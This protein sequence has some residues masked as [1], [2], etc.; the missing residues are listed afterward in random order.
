M[1]LFPI[2]EV[3]S[4][5]KL[6]GR[7]AK[8]EGRNVNG[9]DREQLKLVLDLL[10]NDPEIAGT[11]EEF[12][13]AKSR[14]EVI[15]ANSKFNLRLW[16]FLGI[17]DVYDGEAHRKEM[18]QSV[19]ENVA[20][21][22]KL[23]CQVSFN[24]LERLP[25]IFFPFSYYGELSLAKPLHVEETAYIL[26]EARKPVK[27]PIT[28]AYTLATWSDLGKDPSDLVK[29]GLSNSEARRITIEKL[30]MEFADKIINLSLKELAK[31]GVSRL[32]IDE[33]NASAFYGQ[34]ELFY[35]ATKRSIA[36][37]EGSEIGLHI[38][39][40]N[41]YNRIAEVAAISE[42]RF[43]TLEIANRDTAD[44]RAYTDAVNTFEDVGYKGQYCIGVTDVHTD[45]IEN[46]KLV[47]ERILH[48]AKMVDPNRI[49]AAHDCGLR[50]R[51][52]AVAIEKTKALVKGAEM[53]R[54]YL[55]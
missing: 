22:S 28:G 42:I 49:E 30:V 8:L 50:T 35:E 14:Q 1:T 54:E 19:V 51:K 11:V 15:D 20:G 38:C 37:V 45:K 6:P 39:F 55:K 5:P 24:N 17:K 18:Y 40:S 52:L 44:H 53:A 34:E 3:G 9:S 29:Q 26:R 47:A 46:P 2:F 41:D 31:L 7:L 10:N 36:G 13:L 12:L 43:L 4:L 23:D 33:P 27:V 21:M 32:Q 16:E 48:A 25:N